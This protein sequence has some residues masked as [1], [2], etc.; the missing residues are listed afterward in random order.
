MSP[1]LEKIEPVM[2]HYGKLFR[3]EYGERWMPRDEHIRDTL[4]LFKSPMPGFEGYT[5]EELIARL[6]VFFAVKEPWLVSCKHNYAV[7]LKHIHRWIPKRVIA[8]PKSSAVTSKSD[9]VCPD[10]QEPIKP[11]EVCHVCYPLCDKCN[12]Y[13]AIEDDCEAFAARMKRTM[14]ML[15]NSSKRGGASKQLSELL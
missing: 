12:Q 4:E 6:V 2:V 11:G 7:F 1:E 10:C 14:A 15:S 9:S 3:A 8:D 13:H 5:P